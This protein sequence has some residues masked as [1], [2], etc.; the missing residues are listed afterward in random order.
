M[1]EWK[2]RRGAII[3]TLDLSAAHSKHARKTVRDF[4]RGMYAGDIDFHVG[5]VAAFIEQQRRERRHSAPFLS[6]VILDLPGVD[7][8][9]QAVVDSMHN[10]ATLAVFCPSISQIAECVRA[11]KKHDLPF[12]L[13]QVV[14]LGANNAAGKQWDVRAVRPRA[15]QDKTVREGRDSGDGII[16][17]MVAFGAKFF[18]SRDGQRRKNRNESTDEALQMVCRPKTGYF[19]HGGGFLGLWKRIK[20]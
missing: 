5:D 4:R 19:V 1:T 3:H 7:A 20:S 16:G 9:L 8:H 6:Y 13:E 15:A 12:A 14:E 11:V 18:G 2:A 17:R 10:D